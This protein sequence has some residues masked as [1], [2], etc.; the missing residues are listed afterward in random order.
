MSTYCVFQVQRKVDQGKGEEG[1]HVKDGLN[2]SS[3]TGIDLLPVVK[4]VRTLM[5]A[6]LE[7]S[8]ISEQSPKSFEKFLIFSVANSAKF[9]G[10]GGRGSAAV[11][12]RV[13][14]CVWT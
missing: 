10:T 5:P 11:L 7:W 3:A 14:I 1:R 13:S 8:L 4:A 6:A 12:S 9:I 2:V